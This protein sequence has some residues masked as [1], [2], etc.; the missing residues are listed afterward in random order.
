[1]PPQPYASIFAI[2]SQPEDHILK[3]L[4]A[5]CADDEV[6]KKAHMYLM[7]LA[8][9][10]KHLK[11]TAAATASPPANGTKR[12]R[13]DEETMLDVEICI[14]CEQPF[15]KDDNNDKSCSYHEG[16][17]LTLENLPSSSLTFSFHP[18]VANKKSNTYQMI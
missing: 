17:Y 1:M 2:T 4:T 6:R 16:Q 12:K 10:A 11:E 18:R 8:R 9:H 3:A 15:H 13:E 5:L 7:K 14:Q